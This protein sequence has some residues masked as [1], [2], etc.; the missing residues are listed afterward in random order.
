MSGLMNILAGIEERYFQVDSTGK[1]ALMRLKFARPSDIFNAHVG[2]DTPVFDDDFLNVLKTAHELVPEKY[3]LDLEISFDDW[4]GIPECDL[5]ELIRNG[6]FLGARRS[7]IKMARRNR[8]AIGL[9]SIGVALLAGMIVMKTCWHANNILRDS[10]IYIADIAVTVTFWE[11]LSIM[12]VENSE[13][14][15][16]FKNLV[17]RFGNISFHRECA[18]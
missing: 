2:S 1:R 8:M 10:L 16:F 18:V 12:I 15:S 6:V 9:I 14:R 5:R 11:A 17:R 13:K 3:I 4:E 7:L